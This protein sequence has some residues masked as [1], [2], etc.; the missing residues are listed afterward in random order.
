MLRGACADLLIGQWAW[1]KR[2]EVIVSEHKEIINVH[3]E[4]IFGTNDSIQITNKN[5]TNKI[6]K[7]VVGNFQK[8]WN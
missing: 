7:C 8:G 3:Y 4:E 1:C 2:N 5:V 6:V